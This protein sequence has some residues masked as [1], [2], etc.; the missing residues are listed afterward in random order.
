MNFFLPQYP[1]VGSFCSGYNAVGLAL[2]PLALTVAEAVVGR[3]T[4]TKI[5]ALRLGRRDHG[6]D[7]VPVTEQVPQLLRD[8]Q[9]ELV[10]L[11]FQE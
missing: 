4:R 3:R 9:F 5:A 2:Q 6:F 10:S 8:K 11:C 7:Q 1:K